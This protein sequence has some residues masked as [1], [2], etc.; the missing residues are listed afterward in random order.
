MPKS[1]KLTTKQALFVQEYI[2]D[3]NASRAALDA[4]YSKKTA[5]AIGVENLRKPLIQQAIQKVLKN[6]ADRTN[7]TQDDTLKMVKDIADIDHRDY[8]EKRTTKGIEMLCRCQG[9]FTDNVRHGYDESAV[10]LILKTLPPEQASLTRV[11]LL[12]IAEKTEA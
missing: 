11:V 5:S 3:F 12:Q 1:D 4:K 9:M 8:E 10:E 6:R 2:I 7:I